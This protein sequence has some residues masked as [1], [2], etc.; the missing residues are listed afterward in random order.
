MSF[1]R[2]HASLTVNREGER[3]D[4]L[5][6]MEQGRGRK[7]ERQGEKDREGERASRNTYIL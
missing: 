4:T 7:S 6:D 5:R 1:N 2:L 3:K